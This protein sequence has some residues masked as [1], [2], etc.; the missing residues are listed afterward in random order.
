[1]RQKLHHFVQL[2]VLAPELVDLG[3][4]VHLVGRLTGCL[5]HSSRQAEVLLLVEG[6]ALGQGL[7]KPGMGRDSLVRAILG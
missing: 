6:P 2:C 5:K 4:T 3:P 1:M 7:P